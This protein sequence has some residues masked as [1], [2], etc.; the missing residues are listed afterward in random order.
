MMT[1][2]T[3]WR[4]AT[5]PVSIKGVAVQDGLVLLLRNERQEWELPGGKLE[6][7]ETPEG[8]LA[9]EIEEET[10]WSVEV[11]DILHSWLYHIRQNVDVFVVVYGCPVLTDTAPQLSHEHKEIQLFKPAEVPGLNMPEGYKTAIAKWC[12]LRGLE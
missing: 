12:A 7:G 11:A 9:R 2:Q 3:A 4:P 8:C 1:D 6:I 10:G 5:F